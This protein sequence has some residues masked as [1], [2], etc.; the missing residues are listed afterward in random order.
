M[1]FTSTITFSL[2][3]GNVD[4][5]IIGG[6]GSG[7]KNH[8][9]GGGAGRVV[10]GSIPITANN[11]TV[12]VGSGGDKYLF[13]NGS[14][15][16]IFGI[17]ALGGGRGGGDVNGLPSNGG[18]GGGGA[19]YNQNGSTSPNGATAIASTPG[20]LGNNGGNG[21]LPSA[22]A[23]PAGGGGGGGGAGGPGISATSRVGGIGGS[24]TTDYSSWLTSI[25]DIMPEEWKTATNNGEVIASGGSGGSWGMYPVTAPSGGGGNGGNNTE[26]TMVVGANGTPNTGGGGGGG[27]SGTQEG[28]Y[29]GSGLVIIRYDLSPP[30]FKEGSKILTSKGY[31]R[32]ED[33]RKGDL[34]KT[35][36]HNYLPIEMIGKSSIYN[37]GDSSRIKH[38]LYNL[39]KEKYPELIEDLILTGCHSLLV[40][41]LTKEQE[42]EILYNYGS[43]LLTDGKV[44]LETYLDDKSKPY[45]KEGTYMIYHLALENEDY[46]TNYAIY[47]NGLLV[48]SCSKRYLLELSGMNIVP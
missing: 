12:T 45:S 1:V 4:Y 26:G 6:G 18:S 14:D 36:K 19:G 16:S 34:V 42:N 15:S 37:S 39:S 27:G 23:I 43:F 46:Y 28:G 17:T 29:G 31:K 33:L 9:A 11:Y 47:A 10:S 22:P 13:T 5:L 38:R 41:I 8:G 44:R 2:N 32:V 24:G 30:C 20:N 3:T 7:G 25:Y 21:W 35:L 40:D 48:E